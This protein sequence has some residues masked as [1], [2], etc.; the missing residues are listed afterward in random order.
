M[1]A[2]GK[3]DVA[4][5]AQLAAKEQLVPQKV[6]AF[7]D[8]AKPGVLF[9][10]DPPGGTEVAAGS[11]VKMLVSAGVPNLAFDDSNNVLQVNGFNGKRLKAFAK[12]PSKEKDPAFSPDGT[13]IVYVS[14]R[15][16]LLG[17]TDDPGGKATAL[18]TDS[19]QF[20]DPAFAPTVTANILAANRIKDKDGDLCIGEVG[21]QGYQ[22]A[23]IADPSF[24]TSRLVRWAPDGKSVFV[25]GVKLNN[26][27]PTGTFGMVRYTTKKPFSPN[28]RDYGRGSFVTDNSQINKGAIDL[29]ISPDNETMAVLAN[30]ETDGEFVLF[31]TKPGDFELNE[32]KK[33]DIIGCKVNWRPDSLEMVVVQSEN[34]SK[35]P[36]GE[37]IRVN[38]RDPR[39]QFTIT[40]G[41]DNPEYQ[42]TFT[43]DGE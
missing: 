5:Y 34:C 23:C 41:G 9:A 31:L 16:L 32:A 15:R 17:K 37:I 27:I 10:T 11:K 2:I 25:F 24:S 12:S 19:E 3:N 7:S 21:A 38:R 1:P 6:P 40:S 33:H 26:G 4:A 35:A 22:R 20:A 30:F 18:T 43:E 28:A 8:T 29:A 13:R 14:G 42:P 39:R 36:V